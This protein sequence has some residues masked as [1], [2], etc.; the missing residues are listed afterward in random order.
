LK[1]KK[2]APKTKTKPTK[3]G[4]KVKIEYKKTDQSHVIIG[5]RAFDLF[6]KRNPALEV[7]SAVLGRGFSSRLF[8]KM[9]DKLGM[10]YYVR[11]ENLTST[12]RGEFV[13][14]IGVGVDRVE[15]AV[16]AIVEEFRTIKNELIGE[17]EL[18]KAKNSLLGKRAT[19]L[20]TSED[21]SSFYGFQELL[22]EKIKSPEEIS[23]KIRA[24]TAKQIQN[25]FKKIITNKN[26]NMAIVGPH[27]DEKGL[28]KL[29]RV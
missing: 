19:S 14:S 4:G 24:V 29:L 18:N 2:V 7:A 17:K 20:E 11:A 5:F 13:V 6:D 3:F 26:I 9:R 16:K 27:K 10:C 22:H 15:E 23:K 8:K 1:K 28:E 25:I 21:W 12:D